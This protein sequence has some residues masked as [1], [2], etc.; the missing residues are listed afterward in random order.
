VGV[1][2]HEVHRLGLEAVVARVCEHGQ[3][4]GLC[5]LQVA[6]TAAARRASVQL[7]EIR[8]RLEARHVRVSGEQHERPGRRAVAQLDGRV[9]CQLRLVHHHDVHP[10]HQ[11]REPVAKLLALGLVRPRLA[12]L[13][14]V[15]AS[16]ALERV[17]VARHTQA[18]HTHHQRPVGPVVA[19]AA[20]LSQH[21][22]A[23]DRQPAHEHVRVVV[24]R[25]EHERVPEP[26]DPAHQRELERRPARGE[27]AY[28]E[29]RPR[30]DRAVERWESEQVVVQV[31]R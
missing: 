31:R 6:G 24:A 7:H 20:A 15:V 2:L 19:Q 9:L 28:E 14:E 10:S 16:P 17:R 4:E 13:A 8:R 22:A 18:A 21:S 29:E 23:G 25:D 26:P 1:D 27:V 30:A 12:A 5:L 11:R 3:A